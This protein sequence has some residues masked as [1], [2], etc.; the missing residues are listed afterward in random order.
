MLVF[1]LHDPT[2]DNGP[3]RWGPFPMPLD[4]IVEAKL[5]YLQS[6]ASYLGDR[7]ERID[8]DETRQVTVT[9]YPE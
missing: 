3:M 9:V 7:F 6:V 1:I 2:P 5:A 8:N 4:P